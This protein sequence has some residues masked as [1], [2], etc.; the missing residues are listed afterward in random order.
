MSILQVKF[1]IKLSSCGDLQL[2]KGERKR[3]KGKGREE[4]GEEVK[5]RRRE[6]RRGGRREEEMK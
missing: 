6:E 5:R 1:F 4:E 3:E 2:M